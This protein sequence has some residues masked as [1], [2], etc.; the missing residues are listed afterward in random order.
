MKFHLV[1]LSIATLAG[2][3]GCAS[4]KQD[5]AGLLDQLDSRMA[6]GVALSPDQT[7]QV[8]MLRGQAQNMLSDNEAV[9]CVAAA[10]KALAIVQTAQDDG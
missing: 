2:F 5:C 9:Y 6:S 3:W 4:D 10:K 8:E 1:G 7:S